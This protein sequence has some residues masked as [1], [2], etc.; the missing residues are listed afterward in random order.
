M[1][2]QNK[3]ISAIKRTGLLA[4]S[5]PADS[6]IDDLKSKFQHSERSFIYG[7]LKRLA[8]CLY[9]HASPGVLEATI[10]ELLSTEN[11][12]GKRLLNL[13]GGFGQVSA[14][15]EYLG[16]EVYNI[17]LEVQDDQITAKN[18]R[19]NLN[20][21]DPLPVPNRTFDVVIC[22]E[23]IE[24]LENPWQLFRRAKAALKPDGILVLSTPNI[25]SLSSRLRFWLTGYHKWFTPDSF[26]YHVNPVADWEIK[27][28]AQKTGFNLLKLKG[29]GDYFFHRESLSERKIKNKNEELIYFFTPIN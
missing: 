2:R 26:T 21:P 28:I 16:F 29:N 12:K 4:V 5:P 24:H 6:V 13:G 19:F 8:D 7:F 3:I 18:I 17:D 23:I 15:F 27:L 25:E 22:Q 14:I 9:C 20:S 11:P 10:L 1:T